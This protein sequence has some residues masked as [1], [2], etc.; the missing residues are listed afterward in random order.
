MK[1]F[2]PFKKKISKERGV[3]QNHQETVQNISE[4]NQNYYHDVSPQRLSISPQLFI[5]CSDEKKNDINFVK[6][7]LTYGDG[8]IILKNCANQVREE[9]SYDREIMLRAIKSNGSALQFA[10]EELKNDRKIVFKSIEFGAE[11]FS[12]L[13]FVPSKFLEDKQFILHGL[14][15]SSECYIKASEELK[16]DRDC[17]LSLFTITNPKFALS[18]IP[19]DYL[20][21]KKVLLS[22]L[23]CCPQATPFIDKSLREDKEFLLEAI[24]QNKFVV[25]FISETVFED[26]DFFTKILKYDPKC[27]ERIPNLYEK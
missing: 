20:K 12:G 4:N 24:L 25:R 7:C 13:Q 2:R 27:V 1:S 18:L 23:L 10:C 26:V 16:H 15:F 14:K 8:R 11:N 22:I 6:E 3:T 21:D 17:I 9:L 5:S 19:R